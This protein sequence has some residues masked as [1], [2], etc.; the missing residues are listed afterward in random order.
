[1]D[2]GEETN[3]E[4]DNSVPK[5]K[6]WEKPK[7]KQNRTKPVKNRQG[8][9]TKVIKKVVASIKPE[10]NNKGKLEE[11]KKDRKENNDDMETIG[12]SENEEPSCSEKGYVKELV[13][14]LILL[15]IIFLLINRKQ[16]SQDLFYYAVNQ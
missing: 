5:R 4:K 1:M 13:H 14:E 15:I 12:Y 16:F 10:E 6:I 2:D 11:Q 3:E 9:K 8:Q 7:K